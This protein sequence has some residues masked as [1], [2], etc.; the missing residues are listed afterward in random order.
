MTNTGALLLL[1]AL[2]ALGVFGTLHDMQELSYTAL[3]R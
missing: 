2:I 1:A 3:V